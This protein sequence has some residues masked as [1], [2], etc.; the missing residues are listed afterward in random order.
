MR[1]FPFTTPD[2]LELLDEAGVELIFFSPLHDSQFPEGVDGLYLVGGFPEVYAQTLSQNQAFLDGI[3]QL[4]H[5]NLPIY[6]ECGGLMALTEAVV[7]LDGQHWPMAGIIPGE[8]KM[9]P[10]LASLGYRVATAMTDNLLVDKGEQVRGHEFH[11]STWEVHES[12]LNGYHAWQVRRRQ[13]DSESRFGGYCQGN[14][15]ASYIHVHFGQNPMLARR[16]LHRL[17]QEQP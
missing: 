13:A 3:R 6:A 9:Q 14:L 5:A 1:H 7:D 11:Y 4:H 15:L 10:R 16:F 8:T 2:N 12:D 17:N